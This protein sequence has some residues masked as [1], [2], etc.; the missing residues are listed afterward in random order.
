MTDTMSLSLWLLP[1]WPLLSHLGNANAV[2][3]A[4]GDKILTPK[5]LSK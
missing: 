4:V 5:K 2:P 1:I 3:G